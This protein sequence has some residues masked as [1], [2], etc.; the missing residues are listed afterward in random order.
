[1]LQ[2]IVANGRRRRLCAEP[3]AADAGGAVAS[4]GAAAAAAAAAIGTPCSSARSDGSTISCA[5]PAWCHTPATSNG[6]DGDG[7][8]GVQ[9]A[10][11]GGR[12]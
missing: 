5:T 6:I 12:Q 7:R 4:G 2:P 1:V 3:G 11:G 9:Q 8:N 10:G